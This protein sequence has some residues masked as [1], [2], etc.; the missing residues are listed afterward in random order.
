MLTPRS[1]KLNKYFQEGQENL[2]DQENWAALADLCSE[3]LD[4]EPQ[5]RPNA[6]ETEARLAKFLE[7]LDLEDSSAVE[8]E[9][10]E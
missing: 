4:S 8:E 10:E 1:D 6:K 3:L 2:L 7:D 9:E 5:Q